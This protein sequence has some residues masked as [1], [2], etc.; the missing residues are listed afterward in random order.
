MRDKAS[1]QWRL[2]K[3]DFK[4]APTS[5]DVKNPQ[6]MEKIKL[7]FSD[8]LRSRR[9]FIYLIMYCSSFKE[10]DIEKKRTLAVRLQKDAHDISETWEDYSKLTTKLMDVLKSSRISPEDE[11]YPNPSSV[12]DEMQLFKPIK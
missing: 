5:G 8:I 3:A 10:W 4:P 6:K 9:M 12:I 7:K 2:I 11:S 1:H